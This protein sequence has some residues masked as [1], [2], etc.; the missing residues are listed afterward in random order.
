MVVFQTPLLITM[1]S[2][3]LGAAQADRITSEGSYPVLTLGNVT[4]KQTEAVIDIP[5]PAGM[6]FDRLDA[7]RVPVS[8][9]KAK[10][11]LNPWE[12]RA[13]EVRP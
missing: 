2:L 12:F 3:C 6:L 10:V 13:F 7:A 8:A 11:V 5:V 4:E 1:S 9:G